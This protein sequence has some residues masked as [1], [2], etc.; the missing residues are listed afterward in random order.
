MNT[1]SQADTAAVANQLARLITAGTTG[2]ALVAAVVAR[3]PDLTWRDLSEALQVA[4]SQ[5]ERK[6]LRP[7]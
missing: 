7:H 6:A 5:V 4:Q 2:Q 3:Y 1:P